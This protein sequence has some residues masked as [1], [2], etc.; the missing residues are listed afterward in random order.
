MNK[1]LY[2]KCFKILPSSF[3]WVQTNKQ[4]LDFNRH[5]YAIT[6][7]QQSNG[8]GTKG[9]HWQSNSGG[10]YLT[11]AF[12]K[13]ISTNDKISM[14]KVSLL[15]LT[16]C[17]ICINTIHDIFGTD[18]NLHIKWPND[19]YYNKTKKLGGVKAYTEIDSDTIFCAIGIGINYENDICD[20]TTNFARIKDFPNF[21]FCNISKKEFTD[22]FV[23]N[24]HEN[25]SKPSQIFDLKKTVQDCNK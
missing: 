15:T 8:L 25:L 21:K 12:E 6:A 22:K 13:K 2:K 3:S 7:D 18:T 16:S 1:N 23:S 9:R 19:I 20:E 4:N 17:L 5:S 11:Y 24:L 14:Q 10:I